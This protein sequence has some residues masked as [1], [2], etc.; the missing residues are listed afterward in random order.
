MSGLLGSRAEP[1]DRE[2]AAKGTHRRRALAAPSA[3]KWRWHHTN[4]NCRTSIPKLE[5]E[6]S[7]RATAWLILY[8]TAAGRSCLRLWQNP[9]QH[10]VRSIKEKSCLGKS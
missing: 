3:Q 8:D 7:E 2:D 1:C 5:P 6:G 4:A 10:L 9:F